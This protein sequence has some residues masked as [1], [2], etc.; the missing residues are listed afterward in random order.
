MGKELRKGKKPQ[1]MTVPA[2]PKPECSLTSDEE[3]PAATDQCNHATEIGVIK[4]VP[5]N[6]NEK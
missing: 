1:I 6:G 2:D 5:R 3:S 4:N